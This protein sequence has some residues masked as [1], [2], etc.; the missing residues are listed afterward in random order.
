MTSRLQQSVMTFM[1]LSTLSFLAHKTH[2]GVVF[3]GNVE[4]DFTGSGVVTVV[5]PGAVDVG[6]PL[7]APAGTVS[8]NDLKDV[9]FSYDGTDLSVGF[10]AFTIAG[11]VDNDGNGGTT[12]AWLAGL[13]GNDVADF[14]G[15][16]S[17]ALMI[18]VDENGTIDVIAGVSATTDISGFSVS[19]FS[20]SPFA[21]GF[22]F[23]AALPGHTGSVFGSPN[24]SAPDIEFTITN[25]ASLSTTLGLT[26]P[27]VASFAVNAFVGS[28][29]DAGIGEDFLPGVGVLTSVSVPEPSSFLMCCL[30]LLLG[31]CSW[32]R[33]PRSRG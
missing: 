15:T 1:C 2:A 10:N 27:S 28:F 9:R 26:D 12:S 33:T 22:A 8:G 16:E 24:A 14:G 29:S 23:G 4:S 3:T 6:L 11:D 18:D 17:F 5:D 21:P 13:G 30:A 20:G 32:R 25:F 19:Q 7:A 31:S